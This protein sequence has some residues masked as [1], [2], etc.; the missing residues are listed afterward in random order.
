MTRNKGKARTRHPLLL[1]RRLA[2]YYRRPLVLLLL[3]SAGLLIW[4]PPELQELR[5]TLVLT[6]LLSVTLLLL[7]FLMSRVAHVQCGEYGLRVQL[8]FYRLHVPYDSIVQTRSVPLHQLFRPSKQ[9]FSSQAF[10]NPLWQLPVVLVGMEFLPQP[11]RQLRLWMDSRMIIKNG[12]VFLVQDHRALRRQIDDAMA[13]WRIGT[14]D[15]ER[16]LLR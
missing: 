16:E 8:P 10:L 14:R 4:D 12:L 3:V 9:P 7:T 2:S 13:R 15:T 5:L 6:L 11:R 1:Y